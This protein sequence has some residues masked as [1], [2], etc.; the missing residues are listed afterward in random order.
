[1]ETTVPVGSDVVWAQDSGGGGPV[2]VLLH[3]GVGDSRQWDRV[4]PALTAECR[5]I[6]YDVR[7][8]GRS[9]AATEG[10]TLAGDLRQVLEHFQVERAHLA[11]CSMGGAAAVDLALAEPDRVQSLTLLCP[12]FSGYAWPE[13]PE[14]EAEFAAL[15]AAD[16]EEGIVAGYQRLWAAAGAGPEVMEQLRLAVRAE[17][18]AE[19]YQ[20]PAPPAFDRLHE[21][22]VPTVLLVGDLD[23]PTL[24]TLD[25]EAARRIPGCR[26]IWMPGVDHMPALRDPELVRAT[27][28]DQ[29]AA[30]SGSVPQ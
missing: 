11:G 2:V 17:P 22:S 23:R 10:Y 6:R 8:Y 29:V 21:L 13:E 4:W 1:M 7:G 3:S 9:P 20:R 15:A 14:L 5:V 30:S 26:L 27:I 19:Q 28:L 18:N 16:G 25:Q 12:G 24:I